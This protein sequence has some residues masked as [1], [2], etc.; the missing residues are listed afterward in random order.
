MIS[1]RRIIWAFG[2]IILTIAGTTAL[3]RVPSQ[4]QAS[5]TSVG[6]LMA[7]LATAWAAYEAHSA[8]MTSAASSR[9]ARMALALHDRSWPHVHLWPEQGQGGQPWTW[10]VTL[11]SG[12]AA[13]DLQLIW[14]VDGQIRQARRPDLH[15]GETWDAPSYVPMDVGAVDLRRRVG[16]VE[17][18]WQDKNGLMRWRSSIEIAEG[19]SRGCPAPYAVQLG[20][21][22]VEIPHVNNGTPIAVW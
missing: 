20:T 2:L 13:S 19:V 10:Y 12:A 9:D 14:T 5:L 11:G 3:V 4:W 22:E 16:S 6:A 7:A 1:R 15:D 17:I 8:A 18:Q 21:E